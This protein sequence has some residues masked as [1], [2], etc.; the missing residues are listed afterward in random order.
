MKCQNPFFS[1]EG[2]S[3]RI[4]VTIS[5]NGVNYDICDNCWQTIAESDIEW[6]KPLPEPYYG[7][8]PQETQQPNAGA[9]VKRVEPKLRKIRVL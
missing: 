1:C 7:P 5:V 4:A 2:K 9:S 8:F 3:N 6:G